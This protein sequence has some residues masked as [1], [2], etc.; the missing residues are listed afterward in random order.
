M[1]TAI[2]GKGKEELKMYKEAII[3][4]LNG[5]IEYCESVKEDLDADENIEGVKEYALDIEA[6]KG[7][8]KLINK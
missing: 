7:A 4:R 5:L 6:L 3:K 2:T 8:I 1:V